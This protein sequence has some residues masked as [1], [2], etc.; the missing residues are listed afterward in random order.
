MTLKHFKRL[1]GVVGIQ[2]VLFAAVIRFESSIPW[3]AGL[4]ASLALLVPMV[5]HIWV[6]YDAPLGA[7]APRVVKTALTALVAFGL[8]LVG[9]AAG[10]ITFAVCGVPVRG[11]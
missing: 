9:F 1:A 11:T 10:Y 2:W 6:L 4:A 8:T 5:L 3:L 7:N